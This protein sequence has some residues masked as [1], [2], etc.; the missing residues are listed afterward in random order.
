M[1]ATAAT[2]TV[3]PATAPLSTRLPGGALPAASR[4]ASEGN[5]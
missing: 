5:G 1:L 2:A 3:R 4:P